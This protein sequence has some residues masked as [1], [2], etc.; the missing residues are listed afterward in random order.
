VRKTEE[1]ETALPSG[2]IGENGAD[3]VQPV[4]DDEAGVGVYSALQRPAPKMRHAAVTA[5]RIQ[6]EFVR[7]E[8]GFVSS[9]MNL[10]NEV[11]IADAQGKP[12]KGIDLRAELHTL[13]D[14]SMDRYEGFQR[15]EE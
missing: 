5:A 15:G 2:E 10:A 4:Q 14:M 7:Y 13:V 12:R 8:D 9:P 3:P 1:K 6:I 11:P